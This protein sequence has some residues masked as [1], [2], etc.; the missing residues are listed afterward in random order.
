MGK[1]IGQGNGETGN[2]RRREASPKDA[3][4]QRNGRTN[5]TIDQASGKEMIREAEMLSAVRTRLCVEERE[6]QVGRYADAKPQGK[7]EPDANQTPC[8]I[9]KLVG[10]LHV[11][12]C[13]TAFPL[14]IL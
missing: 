2:I 8:K 12:S 4:R 7:E 14:L 3:E 6:R 13:V 11:L 10:G 1:A 5:G 9:L